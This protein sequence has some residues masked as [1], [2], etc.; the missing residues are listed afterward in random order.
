MIDDA[1]GAVPPGT[2]ICR[3]FRQR[4]S[5]PDPSRR[6]ASSNDSSTR[7]AGR[8]TAGANIGCSGMGSTSSDS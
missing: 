7:R 5:S 4:S 2:W 8:S 6:A 3:G 1:G